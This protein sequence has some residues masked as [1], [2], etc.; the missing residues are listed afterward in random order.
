MLRKIVIRTAILLLILAIP[1]FGAE[2]SPLEYVIDCL[3]IKENH[4]IIEASQGS[5]SW[6]R[7]IDRVPTALTPWHGNTARLTLKLPADQ[8]PKF[9]AWN[10]FKEDRAIV[11]LEGVPPLKALFAGSSPTYSVWLELPRLGSVEITAF[12]V[13]PNIKE[14]EAGSAPPCYPPRVEFGWRRRTSA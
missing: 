5:L 4:G 6:P 3:R 13:R 14:A 1:V 10:G 8:V 9:I 7:I 11:M 12:F 2:E